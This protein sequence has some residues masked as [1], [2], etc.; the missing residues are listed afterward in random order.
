MKTKRIGITGGIGSGKTTACK[1]FELLGIPVYYADDRAKWL[2]NNDPDL[3]QQLMDTF[4]TQ[5]Y[6]EAG[7]LNRPFLAQL[8]FNDRSQL[9][10]LN[11]IVHP[12]V[13][14]DGI[15][16]DEAH[17]DTPYTLREAALLYESGIYKLLDKIICV[18]A[19]ES[20]RIARV[21]ARDN[22]TAEA[23]KARIDKQWPEQDKIQL[24]D[25]IIQNDGEQS[26][27]RQVYDVHVVLRRK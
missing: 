7:Q 8:V 19:P 2:M 25:Y 14:A 12:A 4:G 21:I 17:R 3:K 27:I 10:K 6:D 18:T 26:L 15:R 23:V 9:D 16:W 1:L 11:S 13:R 22:T 20:V 24:A 5:T